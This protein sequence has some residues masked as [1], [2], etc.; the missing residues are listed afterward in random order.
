MNFDDSNR[1]YQ[2]GYNDGKEGR[3]KNY[4]RAGKTW[5]FPLGGDTTLNSY[6]SSY[7]EGYRKGQYDRMNGRDSS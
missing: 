4:A 1:G 5:K 6:C 3:D 7:D 2:D